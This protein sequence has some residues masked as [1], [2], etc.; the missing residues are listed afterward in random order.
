MYT[1]LK[2]S[3][4]GSRMLRTGAWRPL[5]DG[6]D[7]LSRGCKKQFLPLMSLDCISLP[8]SMTIKWAKISRNKGTESCS[9]LPIFST[10][11]GLRQWGK[12]LGNLGSTIEHAIWSFIPPNSALLNL[13]SNCTCKSPP[14]FFGVKQSTPHSLLIYNLMIFFQKASFIKN[15]INKHLSLEG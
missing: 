2:D 15:N 8:L 9:F 1:V 12:I 3:Q 11:Q 14:R 13:L 7:R 6:S 4:T 10:C 5:L